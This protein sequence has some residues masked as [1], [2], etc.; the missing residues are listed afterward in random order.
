MSVGVVISFVMQPRRLP[1]PDRTESRTITGALICLLLVWVPILAIDYPLLVGGGV[2]LA[3]GVIFKSSVLSALKWTR[4]V[5][6]SAGAQM[7]E[8]VGGT[9][10]E[11]EQ[12]IPDDPDHELPVSEGSS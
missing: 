4:S 9:L 11:P 5:I 6:G 3:A 10:P 1:N 2:G 8:R 12:P 7:V